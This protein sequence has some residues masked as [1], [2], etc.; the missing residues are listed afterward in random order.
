MSLCILYM[1]TVPCSDQAVIIQS[2]STTGYIDSSQD[3]THNHTTDFCTPFC[4]CNCCATHVLNQLINYTSSKAGEPIDKPDVR[5]VQAFSNG[6][7]YSI[8]QPP[9]NCIS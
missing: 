1:S 9:R 8:W 5:Y 7:H 6:E 2:G 3:N 4:A